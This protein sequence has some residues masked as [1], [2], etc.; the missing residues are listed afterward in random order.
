[1]RNDLRVPTKLASGPAAALS[2]AHSTLRTEDATRWP[3]DPAGRRSHHPEAGDAGTK[4]PVAD[5]KL[6][7]VG[8]LKES[9]RFYPNK[10]WRRTSRLVR[11]TTTA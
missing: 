8:L 4:Q 3:S 10:I 2:A 5:L 9:R 1:M 11:H 6:D 7:G